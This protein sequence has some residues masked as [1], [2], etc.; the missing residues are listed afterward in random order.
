MEIQV[1]LDS[2]ERRATEDNL[3]N[4]ECQAKMERLVYLGIEVTK[5]TLVFLEN[6]AVLDNLDRKAA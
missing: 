1:D 2:Q 4:L 6:L 5:E 3:E